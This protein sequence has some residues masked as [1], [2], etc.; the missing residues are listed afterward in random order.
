MKILLSDLLET[1][2]LCE[3]CKRVV[4]E[5]QKFCN[6]CEISNAPYLKTAVDK[7]PEKL[8]NIRI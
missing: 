4:E 7:K 6:S 1:R 2:N 8:G 3:K 5:N